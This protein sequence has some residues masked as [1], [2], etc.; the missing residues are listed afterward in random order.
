MR[1]PALLAFTGLLA[2]CGGASTGAALEQPPASDAAPARGAAIAQG[3]PNKPDAKPAFAEQTRAPQSKSNVTL[4]VE[5]IADG[6][7]NPWGS[8][9]LPDDGAVL[10]TSKAGKLWLVAPGKPTR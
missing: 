9:I 2:A 4:T 3:E 10:V 6:I 5:T 7:D 8:A 1:L